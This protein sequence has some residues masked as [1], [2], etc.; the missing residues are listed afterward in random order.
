MQ[1]VE[2]N[3]VM[4]FIVKLCVFAMTLFFVMFFVLDI[5]SL[6]LSLMVIGFFVSVLVAFAFLIYSGMLE[7]TSYEDDGTGPTSEDLKAVKRVAEKFNKIM[8]VSALVVTTKEFYESDAFLHSVADGQALSIAQQAF[9]NPEIG[10]FIGTDWLANCR[11]TTILLTDNP[12]AYNLYREEVFAVKGFPVTAL[13]K[14][15]PTINKG[16]FGE[17][18]GFLVGPLASASVEAAVRAHKTR[19]EKLGYN[20]SVIT[21]KV[22][23]RPPIEDM[24]LYDVIGGSNSGCATCSKTD[25]QK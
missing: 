23:E 13:F 14:D 17:V 1:T 11:K 21:P 20:V 18:A 22:V 24:A 5:K 7:F 19:A 25:K 4:S 12:D 10:C 9:R 3:K 16:C 8:D 2:K 15:P 6:E